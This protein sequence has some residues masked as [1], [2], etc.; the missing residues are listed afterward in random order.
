MAKE[1]NA[2]QGQVK[3]SVVMRNDSIVVEY[4]FRI[5]NEILQ[6]FARESGLRNVRLDCMPGRLK[7]MDFFHLK[8]QTR[9]GFVRAGIK[10]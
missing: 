1:C 10:I 3:I 2:H 5:G 6:G 8:A 7:E 4:K 9:I